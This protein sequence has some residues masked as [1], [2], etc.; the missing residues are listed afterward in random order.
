MGQDSIQFLSYTYDDLGNIT[1]RTDE[2]KG[3]AEDFQYDGINRLLK[4]ILVERDTLSM[5]YDAIGNLT[6]KSDVG[7]YNYAENGAGPH[8]VTSING[9]DIENWS[10]AAALTQYMTFT[11]FQKVSNI[12]NDTASIAIT[13][14]EAYQRIKTEKKVNGQV[15]ERKVYYDNLYERIEQADQVVEVHY[16]RG[17]SGVVAVKRVI[18]DTQ[19]STN[20]WH[21]DHLG[22]LETLTDQLGSKVAS[23]SYDAWGRRRNAETWESYDH[24][25]ENYLARGFTGHEHYDL[26][27]LVDMN[28]RI[29]DPVLARFTSPDPF[30]QDPFNIQSYN[31]Y[32]YV[33]NNPLTYTDPSGYFF[34]K[35]FKGLR[36]TIGGLGR[37]VGGVLKG[38]VNLVESAGKEVGRFYEKH[39]DVI[40]PIV[41][42]LV[43]GGVAGFA[44]AGYSAL[45]VAVGSAAG[46]GFGQG[47]SSAIRSGASF[48][49]A[50]KAGVKSAVISGVTSLA[51]FGVGEAFG[52]LTIKGNALHKF[53]SHGTV[54]GLSAELQGGDFGSGFV[55]GSIT[56]VSQIGIKDISYGGQVVA[57]AIVGG[58]ASVIAGGKFENGAVSGAMISIFNDQW[59]K[60]K[61]AMSFG[62]DV[63]TKSV[64]IYEKELKHNYPLKASQFT[65]GLKHAG[66]AVDMLSGNF[67][68]ANYAVTYVAGAIW[69]PLGYLL[70][71]PSIGVGSDIVDYQAIGRTN[72][73]N[74][75][76]AAMQY[77][78]IENVG[79]WL[80]SNGY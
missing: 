35:L 36:R 62:G 51:S 26:L 21:K 6:Y 17:A 63:L 11:S 73:I 2:I 75:N 47:V 71:S 50:L 53:L 58:T 3:L 19:V 76:K 61:K 31:R 79:N 54:Q 15:Y 40:I 23:F 25:V 77:E 8:A 5:T 78:A 32:T 1:S 45:T 9:E 80:K 74:Y 4:A 66:T 64:E 69:G 7:S 56:A 22:S 57:S 43:T 20:Y 48:G 12:E 52:H 46:F 10:L 24:S 14:D 67:D 28:G 27:G 55:S 38:A 16:I 72:N 13:Y 65:Q 30:I 41:A 39:K 37:A 44:L 60:T 18:D 70:D 34:K 42:G 59:E 68:P 33:L 49:D 29:Y